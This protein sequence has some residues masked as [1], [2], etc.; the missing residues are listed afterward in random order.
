MRE[1]ADRLK[2]VAHYPAKNLALAA[3]SLHPVAPKG[4]AGGVP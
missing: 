3:T 2:S 4:T 1:D